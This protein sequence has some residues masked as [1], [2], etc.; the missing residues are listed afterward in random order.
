MKRRRLAF[1][2]G[3]PIILSLIFLFWYASK[4]DMYQADEPK[5]EG[6][7]LNE[8]E[9]EWVK[10]HSPV[11]LSV[12]SSL[13][14]FN[15]SGFLETYLNLL[16]EDVDLSVTLSGED[17]GTLV[18]VNNANREELTRDLITKPLFQI[19]GRLYKRSGFQEK[20]EYTGIALKGDFTDSE[21]RRLRYKDNPIIITEVK[22]P[23]EAVAVA[24]REESDFILGDTNA[25]G[26]ALLWADL[27]DR[28]EDIG[29]KVFEN[30]VCIVVP[31]EHAIFFDI[32]N[33]CII[34][35]PKEVYLDNTKLKTGY[36]PMV[37]VSENKNSYNIVMLV[38]IFLTVFGGFFIY[39]LSTRNLYDELTVRMEQLTESKNEMQTT[40][41]GVSSF[42]AELDRQ[43]RVLIM[44]R[45]MRESLELTTGE[46]AE[47]HICDVM[48]IDPSDGAMIRK[49]I[50]RVAAGEYVET[51]AAT[52]GS[53]TF[54]IQIYPIRN[55]RL[56]VEKLLF[57]GA[58]VTEVKIAQRQMLQQNKMIAVGQLAAGVA[59]EIRNPLGL[60]RNYCY[61]LKNID[62]DEKKNQAIL[63]IEKAVETSGEIIT[64]LLNFS[65]VS[66]G[67]FEI[68]NIVSHMESVI[69][70]NEGMLKKKK[71][72]LSIESDG[73]YVVRVKKESFDMI[74]INLLSNAVDAISDSGHITV[75]LW[76]E[77]KMLYMDVSDTGSG[78]E[79][80][81]LNDIFNP[82]FTTKGS[83]HGNGLGLYI[84]YNEVEK[85][86]GSIRV[87]S[88][89]GE[90]TTFSLRL[91]ILEEEGR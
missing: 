75:K 89:V 35:A 8:K 64:A 78:I 3:I 50:S 59:H 27:Q 57:M 58:D 74:F 12:D 44:N 6:I 76:A 38:I 83:T 32:L 10:D 26:S 24:E 87:E 70:I 66:Q 90:G 81:A 49:L 45:Y 1:L 13:L 19:E 5:G 91:P 62:D 67:E 9:V 63:M 68:I 30:N 80:D 73:E 56:D 61:V 20:E 21:K 79:K 47:K 22:N 15:E 37:G 65:R 2:I 86:N 14:Y 36:S 60:I 42:M 28:Y 69:L 52:V 88:I 54:D 53:K 72:E 18:V 85:M 71:I 43:G 84:V 51:Y 4:N 34:Q 55:Q 31:K 82:F 16:V 48:G 41:N 39:Y 23:K 11:R 17:Y 25:I 40:F 7:I 29:H 33:E 46:A 77:G